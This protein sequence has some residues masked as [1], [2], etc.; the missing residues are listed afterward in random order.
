MSTI[1]VCT[2][3]WECV[4]VSVCINYMV[5]KW[6]I[7]RWR[8]VLWYFH[9]VY[10]VDNI[11]MGMRVIVAPYSSHTYSMHALDF[12]IFCEHDSQ[13]CKNIR[14]F[15]SYSICLYRCCHCVCLLSCEPQNKTFYFVRTLKSHL[16]VCMCTKVNWSYQLENP[17]EC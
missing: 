8:N 7:D 1:H 17:H 15:F 13:R 16:Y 12:V 2:H 10:T 9:V 3:I 6:F 4:S 11:S 5:S 14:F